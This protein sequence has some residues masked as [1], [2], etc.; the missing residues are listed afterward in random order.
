MFSQIIDFINQGG[1]I[2]WVITALYFLVMTVTVERAIFFSRTSCSYSSVERMLLLA[3][4]ESDADALA[5]EKKITIKKNSQFVAI[6]LHYLSIRNLS[7]K[8]FNESLERKAF[9]LIA[10]MERHIWILSQVGHIAP[11]LGLLGTVIGLIEAFRIMATLG[12]SADVASFASGIWVA[13]ITTALGLIVAIPSI[14]LFK[15][16]EKIVEK[17]STRMSYVVSM[18]NEIFSRN[19]S[20]NLQS[21]NKTNT[22]TS[23]EDEL[24]ETF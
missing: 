1:S 9:V 20:S 14:F 7:E 22:V 8:A 10:D 24:H 12:A 18:L 17:R 15:I 16:F 6:L 23:D 11:L 4:C 21:F 3:K 19:P 5:N 2:A 13:M